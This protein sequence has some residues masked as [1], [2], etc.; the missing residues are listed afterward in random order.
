MAPNA[1]PADRQ[2]RD[3]RIRRAASAPAT[4]EIGP[5]ELALH[6]SAD[7]AWIAVKGKVYD[8]TRFPEEHP[9]G[10]IILTYAG[11]DATDVFCAFHPAAT[12]QM[13]PRFQVGTLKAR[14]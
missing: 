14:P 1:V 2:A 6:H 3:L 10:E 7:S 13:L 4:R 8:I 5:D 12:W 9:G 11:R